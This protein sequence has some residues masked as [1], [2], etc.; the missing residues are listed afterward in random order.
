MSEWTSHPEEVELLPDVEIGTGGG[1]RLH[2]DIMRPRQKS[3]RPL[4][5]VLW[6]HGGAWRAGSRKVNPT[7]FLA[8]HGYVTVGVEYR[9]S[10]EAK[11]PAQLEDCRLAVRWLRA[12]GEAYHVNPGRIACWGHSTGGHLA[13]CLGTMSKESRYEGNG[14]HSGVSSE[15][16][17]VVNYCGPV[18]L[19]TGSYDPNRSA[20]EDPSPV[21]AELFGTTYSE[22]K[23]LWEEASP[24]LHVRDAVPHLL[25]HGDADQVVPLAQSQRF[26]AALRQAEVPLEFVT[27][28]SG[29]H[30][31]FAPVGNPDAE[32]ARG[33]ILRFLD[34]HL[35][36]S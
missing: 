31:L 7:Q 29:T 16:Q 3:S 18:D 23:S 25:I 13:S 33:K 34:K 6:I 32:N 15:V 17:A 30:S 26:A 24:F 1:R 36:G 5:A 27:I 35:Q 28:R 21:L 20:G 22:N 4:P 10:G 12:Q 9:L 14:G 2:V 19:S 11:W 8:A